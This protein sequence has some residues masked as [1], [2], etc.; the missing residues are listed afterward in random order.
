VFVVAEDLKEG[1]LVSIVC[2]SNPFQCVVIVVVV[3]FV[4]LE[5]RQGCCLC[6]MVW[7]GVA[8]LVFVERGELVS[9]SGV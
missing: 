2:G 8:V 9:E 1:L 7:K 4:D 5:S 6:Q 3:S